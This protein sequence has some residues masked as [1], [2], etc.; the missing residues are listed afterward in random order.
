MADHEELATESQSLALLYELAARTDDTIYPRIVNLGSETN[1]V[2]LPEA[3]QTHNEIPEDE[4][5]DYYS[6][7]MVNQPFPPFTGNL[8]TINL[9]YRSASDRILPRHHIQYRVVGTELDSITLEKYLLGE[10]REFA[11][12]DKVQM[13]TDIKVYL[14]DLDIFKD[15]IIESE[16]DVRRAL[17]AISTFFIEKIKE[18]IE[19]DSSAQEMARKIG[20][21]AVHR[22]EAVALLE[23]FRV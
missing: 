10:P 11:K 12:L 2:V 18:K 3:L 7:S 17:G 9:L 20:L 4:A 6:V 19:V 8:A 22:D 15:E 14:D 23:I 21:A 5:A 1:I 16:E 13:R